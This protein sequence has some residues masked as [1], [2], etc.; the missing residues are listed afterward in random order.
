MHPGLH[1][2]SGNAHAKRLE[3]ALADLDVRAAF[4]DGGAAG[5]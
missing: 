5:G 3:K 2:S 4:G 1:L